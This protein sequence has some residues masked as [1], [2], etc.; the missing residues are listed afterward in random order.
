MANELKLAELLATRLCHDITGP[1]GAVNNGVE[2]LEED[3][4]A[5]TA[6]ALELIASSAKEAVSRVQ[7]FRQAYGTVK[8]SGEASLEELKGLARQFFAT[9]KIQLDWPDEYAE[10]SEVSI[11]RRMGKLLL[12]LMIIG[13]EALIRGGTLSMR[14][15]KTPGGKQ[16]QVVAAGSQLKPEEEA[17]AILRGEG[18]PE[19]LSPRSV[20]PYLAWQLVQDLGAALSL[21]IT[22]D[23]LELLV[24]KP[25]E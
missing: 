11:S 10:G 5:M 18:D 21:N 12:N 4:E 24:D 16:V 9:G 14:L 13:S 8:F 23:R 25:E 17:V 2:F 15:K 22:E 1:I 19:A 6:Q 3:N 7:Y 20:Q